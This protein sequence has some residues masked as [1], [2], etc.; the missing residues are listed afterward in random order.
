[1]LSG[2]KDLG[3]K[4]A[5]LTNGGVLIQ[6][7]KV[8]LLEVEKYFDAVV[9]ARETREK[10]DSEAYK[11]SIE[12]LGVKAGSTLCV[13]DNPYTDFLG[14]K[15]LGMR[16]VRLFSGEFKRVHLNDDYEAEIAVDSL[17]DILDIV[18]CV[19]G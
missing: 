16:T 12:K 7:N 14:A 3:I 15:K 13:G 2:L 19:N 11:V 6:R 8:H 4:L 1:M 18:R 5:L 9:Y 10:P 17:S